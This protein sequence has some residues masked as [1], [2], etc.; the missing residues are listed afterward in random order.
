MENR[1]L[2]L[3]ITMWHLNLEERENPVIFWA[4]RGVPRKR[5][6]R[7]RVGVEDG[8]IVRVEPVEDEGPLEPGRE[9]TAHKGD[10]G[11]GL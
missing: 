8:E 11:G 6:D 10:K 5:R 7:D 4:D 9:P 2:Q 3:M 1:F